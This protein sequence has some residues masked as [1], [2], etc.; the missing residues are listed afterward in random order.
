M[1]PAFSSTRQAATFALLLLLLLLAPALV[2]KKFLPPREEIYSSIWWENGDFPYMDGQIFREK[3]DIDIAFMGSSHIWAAFDTPKVQEQLSKELNHP[4]IIRTF[5]WG[6]PGFDELYFVAKDLLKHRH[7]RMLVIDDGF[8]ASDQPHLL[9]SR[10][11]RYG[12]D[13]GILDGLPAQ[14]QAAYYFAAI[15]GMPRNLVS[16]VRPNLPADLNAP[17]YWETRSH[18]ANFAARLGTFTAHTGFR[19]NPSAEAEPF[20][21]YAPQAGA[22]PSD[23][24][25]FSTNTEKNFGFPKLGMLPPTQLH[26]AQ[27]FAALVQEHGCK[28]VLLHI[29]TFDERRSPWISEPAIWPAALHMDVTMIGIPPATMFRGMT[30]DEIRKL[31]SDSVH[32]NENGQNYFTSLMTPALLKT[33]ESIQNP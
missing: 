4:A 24:C 32:L 20:V 5:G 10:M 15:A 3:G 27:K 23:V 1:R 17:N 29:P 28:L 2:G 31:Y 33:Y 7:V 25:L 18:A 14:T 16:L 8:N 26:F 6:G 12:D 11:F 9:A 19:E 30:D 21:A 22:Q 13:A